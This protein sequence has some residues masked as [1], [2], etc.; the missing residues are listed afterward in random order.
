MNETDENR[1]EYRKRTHLQNKFHIDRR[2]RYNQLN[3]FG[4]KMNIF[5]I[6]ID[7]PDFNY[8]ETQK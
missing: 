6:G 8:V 2:L 4:D 1:D 7:R 5:S 3:D